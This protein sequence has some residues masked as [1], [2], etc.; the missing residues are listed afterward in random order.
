M[1][2]TGL[3]AE[4]DALREVSRSGA[5]DTPRDLF[6]SRS[7]N[8]QSL[9][10]LT[11]LALF[12]RIGCSFETLAFDQIGLEYLDSLGHSADLVTTLERRDI[13]RLVASREAAHCRCHR[14]ERVNH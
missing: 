11:T 12:I 7:L 9:L 4:V 6:S 13:D 3:A 10:G 5:L 8:L 14:E 1:E 2:K